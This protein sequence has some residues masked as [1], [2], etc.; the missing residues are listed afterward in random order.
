MVLL[1]REF[2]KWTKC[3]CFSA[4]SCEVNEYSHFRDGNLLYWVRQWCGW[5]PSCQEQ[6]SCVLLSLHCCRNCVP[7][8]SREQLLPLLPLCSSTPQ[9]ETSCMI[10]H[11]NEYFSWNW[12]FCSGLVLATKGKSVRRTKWA[13]LRNWHVE[14]MFH[15]FLCSNQFLCPDGLDCSKIQVQ[16]LCPSFLPASSPSSLPPPPGRLSY[17]FLFFFFFSPVLPSPS[18]PA[19]RINP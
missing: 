5:I 1:S 19:V 8:S 15:M 14:V 10:R 6:N 9:H 12:S 2:S 17:S 7:L 11:Q 18:S 16:S 3:G 13:L 4:S